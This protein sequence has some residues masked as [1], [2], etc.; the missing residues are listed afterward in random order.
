ITDYVHPMPVDRVELPARWTT[1]Q[2]IPFDH[3][4]VA[5]KLA[6]KEIGGRL[7]AL[8]P[9]TILFLRN[10]RE[11]TWSVGGTRGAIAREEVADAGIRR[12]RL[13][14]GKGRRQQDERWLVFDRAVQLVPHR[15]PNHVEIAFSLDTDQEGREHI[16]EAHDPK[17]VA[18]FPTA[19]ETHL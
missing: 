2:I 19:R 1:L 6:C 10:L 9:R 13:V 17:L 16:V 4:D 15:P 7:S 8:S 3:N 12:V 14:H 11:L 5:A 18:F